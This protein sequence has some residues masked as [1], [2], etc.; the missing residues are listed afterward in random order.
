[1]S[2]RVK[3]IISFISMT[4]I[5]IGLFV[6]F[7]HIL[8]NLFLTNIEEMKDFYEVD[9][10][11]IEAFFYEELAAITELTQVAKSEPD[12]LLDGPF[13]NRYEKLLGHRQIAIIVKKD[14]EVIAGPSSELPIL[15][16]L[17]D[18]Q[19]L[20][21]QPYVNHQG[22][23]SEASQ[24]WLYT[25]TEFY[26]ND[27]SN[28]S[29]F[30][31]LDVE[32]V[33]S[34][35]THVIPLLVIGFIFAYLLTN[36]VII[37]LISKHLIQPLK[38]LHRSATEIANGNLNQQTKIIRKDEIGELANAFEEM[39]LKLRNSLALQEKYEVNR[40]ELIN[41]ISHDLKTPITSIKGHVQG[42][43]DGVAQDKNKLDTYIQVIHT[44]A[45]E[46]DKLIDELLLFSKLDLNSIPFE[47]EH[48]NICDYLNDIIEELRMEYEEVTFLTDFKAHPKSHVVADRTQLYKVFSNL[49]ANSVKFIQH[50][51][52]VIKISASVRGQI[53]VISVVDNGQGISQKDLPY[54]FE[55][56]Y[57]AEGSRG[58]KQGGSG[59]GLAIVKQIIEAH[60]GS[61]DINS[62]VNEGTTVTLTLRIA[63]IVESDGEDDEANTNYRR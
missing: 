19:L 63:N 45:S 3:L 33:N 36:T 23:I 14:G 49:I 1:M 31:I 12:H 20:P 50:K 47:F 58:L 37:Y 48:V 15:S 13:L 34:F 10:G 27:G 61:V 52:K 22:Q 54:V 38:K 42:I 28:G 35:L 18:H 11:A 46:M 6:L 41:N 9:D 59:I 26:F 21:H 60:Q 43:I 53:M 55:R 24:S 5:P 4:V 16:Q 30:F 39:R 32:P 44:K 29:L 40:K 56:F 57:R 7:L 25:G 51:E 2:I 17:P 62:K 8:F